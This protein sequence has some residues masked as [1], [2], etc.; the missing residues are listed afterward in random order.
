MAAQV[1]TDKLHV[2]QASIVNDLTRMAQRASV[3]KRQII[4]PD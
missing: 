2:R 3:L 1:V 4:P